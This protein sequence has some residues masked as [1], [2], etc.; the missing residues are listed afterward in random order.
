M[1]L[2]LSGHCQD[3]AGSQIALA[4]KKKDTIY[5]AVQSDAIFT[6]NGPTQEFH[7]MINL[8]PIVPN[9]DIKDSLAENEKPL[10]LQ[11]TGRFPVR[12]MGFLTVNDNNKTYSMECLCGIY[13]SSKHCSLNFNLMIMEDR[14]PVQDITGAPFYQP[15][16]SFAMVL[17]PGDYG[18]DKEPFSII[19]PVMIIV[20]DVQINKVQ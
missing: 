6:L 7:A 4:L 13:D 15:R 1:A 2:F 3:K 9:P 20:K 19:E 10:H 11:I 14:P 8:F 5:N 17:V 18:L 16:L 12:N